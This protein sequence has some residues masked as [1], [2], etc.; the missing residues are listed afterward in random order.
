MMAI[1]PYGLTARIQRK[2]EFS[3]WMYPQPSPG[4]SEQVFVIHPFFLSMSNKILHICF[5]L[6]HYQIGRM[7]IYIYI[8][9]Y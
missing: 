2:I 4:T 5:S 9:A 8:P 3:K 7:D 6:Y 1:Q